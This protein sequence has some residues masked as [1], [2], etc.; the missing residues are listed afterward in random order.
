MNESV[1]KLLKELQKKFPE[2][3]VFQ[4]NAR[5]LYISIPKEKII[6]ITKF[7]HHENGLRLS[8]ATG[9]DTR[10]GFEIL[11]HFSY[12]KFGTYFTIKVLIPKDNPKIQSIAPYYPAANWIERE[13]HELLGID[14]EGHPNLTPLLT[15]EDWPE[16]KF[17]LRRDYE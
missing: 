2:A 13:I 7:L 6:N 9:I 8:I 16:D 5:R 17:P 15:A 14:F 1:E 10:E 4:H 3:K 11:Y 12:D